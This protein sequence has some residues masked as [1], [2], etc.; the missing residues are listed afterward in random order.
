MPDIKLF[1]LDED[2]V[3]NLPKKWQKDTMGGVFR[4]TDKYYG[5]YME[6][7]GK[8]IKIRKGYQW[9]GASFQISIFGIFQIGT[10][11]GEIDPKTGKRRLYYATMI[12]DALTMNDD[13]PEMIYTR[14]EMD[15]LFFHML[16]EAKWGR[17]KLYYWAVRFWSIISFQDI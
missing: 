11:N 8:T 9:N 12:H 15:Q 10:Y 4:F 13:D 17:A 16:K 6:L 2:Y 5:L 3:Y 14:K 7:D 1:K